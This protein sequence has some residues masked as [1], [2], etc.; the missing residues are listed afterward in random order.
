MPKN[1]RIYNGLIVTDNPKEG[2]HGIYLKASDKEPIRIVNFGEL[3]SETNE[4]NKELEEAEGA[5]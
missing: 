1:Y 2:T 3:N 4:I 5:D